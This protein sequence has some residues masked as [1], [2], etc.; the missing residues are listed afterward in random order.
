MVEFLVFNLLALVCF[1]LARLSL[2][3]GL[4]A[5]FI[6]VWFIGLEGLF[7]FWF[8]LR[9]VFDFFWEW[10]FEKKRFPVFGWLT[11]F[12]WLSWIAWLVWL[13]CEARSVAC[14]WYCVTFELFFEKRHFF[15]FFIGVFWAC[16]F[17]RKNAPTPAKTLELPWF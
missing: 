3:L 14:S 12:A 7:C 9:L 4:L 5:Y 6:L 8:R 2:F 15:L 10:F 13:T 16:F 1:E 17:F 11:S